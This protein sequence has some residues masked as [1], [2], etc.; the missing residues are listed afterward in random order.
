MN[1]KIEKGKCDY[2][3]SVMV[4]MGYELWDWLDDSILFRDKNFE[5]D[6]VK[7]VQILSFKSEEDVYKYAVKVSGSE[8]REIA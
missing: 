2:A 5:C 3:M 8:K 4:S 6:G 1:K 7:V